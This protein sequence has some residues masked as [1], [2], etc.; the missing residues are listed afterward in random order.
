VNVGGAVTITKR[1]EKDV[2][3]KSSGMSQGKTNLKMN[4][5]IEKL[6]RDFGSEWKE[7][8]YE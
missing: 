4:K 3:E 6:P 1:K 5:K 8:I 2:Y 7:K